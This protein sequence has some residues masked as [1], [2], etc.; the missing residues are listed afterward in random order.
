MESGD[1]A[2]RLTSTALVVF[3]VPGLALFYRVRWSPDRPS[4]AR[5]GRHGSAPA[6]SVPSWE[7][8]HWT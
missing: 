2:W 6:P 1:L 8:L 5:V 7:C 4:E 3:M